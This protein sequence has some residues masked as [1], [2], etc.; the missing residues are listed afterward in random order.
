MFLEAIKVEL[1]AQPTDCTIRKD[2][3]QLA[4]SLDT[5]FLRVGTTLANAVEMIDRVIAGLDGVAAALDERT[6]GAAVADLRQVAV[7]LTNLPVRQAGRAEHMAGVATIARLLNEHVLEMH[8][9]LRVLS[10]YG[11]NIKIAASGEE[12]FVGFVEG[13]KVKLGVGEQELGKFIA[14]LKELMRS[15]AS[16]QQADRL[17]AAE[18]AK[19]IPAIPAQLSSDAAA[20]AAHLT[21]VATLARSVSSI[22]R[23]VQ[24]KVAVVL[25]ALQVGD[26]T[27]QRLEHVV[28]ALQMLQTSA[29]EGTV[30]TAMVGHVERML[31]AQ[32]EAAA[33]DFERETQ[34]MMSSLAD[35]VPDTSKLLD[36]I[37]EQNDGGGRDFLNRLERGIT[38]VEH[39]TA[40]LRDT[41]GRSRA[42]I[43]IITDTVA[44]LSVRL[45][46]VQ[47]IRVNVQDIATN[48]RLL[49]RRHGAT[50]RA[51]SVI[52]TEVDANAIQL[53][54]ATT[55][56]A[57]AIGDLGAIEASLRNGITDA[58]ERD[59][60]KTLDGALGIVRRAC[61]RTEQ[62]A[63][64]GS[65]D[66]GHLIEML[67]VTGDELKQ[68]LGAAG[69]MR[70][71]AATLSQRTPVAEMNESAEAALLRLLPDI[72]RLYTMAQE[73]TV[74]AGFL[75]P[76]MAAAAE[77]VASVDDDDDDGLF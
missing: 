7:D 68:E 21:G 27:R 53:G 23:S 30:D 19:V 66:I 17:L 60:G 12:Q 41:D 15:V 59:M 43:G 34:A 33:T 52:A 47:R 35:L 70:D 51:V 74:H 48:T 45:V 3:A 18:S 4:A 54:T 49:C 25:G 62:V 11:M 44:E 1:P 26:S 76:G 40:R 50:G 72:A 28:S 69:M 63:M 13:M 20:L 2:L 22:A 61:Q 24:G 77:P 71:A 31:A 37:A 42:M 55:Q 14:Q 5:Q 6:A 46:S 65:D 67:I 56:V 29:G 64:E 75:L 9:T 36:L 39:L 10:I 57:R 58:D 16:V 38:D 8:Q 73:R 32:L